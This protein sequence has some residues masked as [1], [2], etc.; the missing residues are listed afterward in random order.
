MKPPRHL[1]R[2]AFCSIALFLYAHALAQPRAENLIRDLACGACHEGLAA[3]DSIAFKA[4]SLSYAGIRYNPAYLFEY[5]GNPKRVR[6]HIGS[7]R[8]PD[9]FL[10]EKERIALTFFLAQQKQYDHPLPIFPGELLRAARKNSD[11]SG[12]KV[13]EELKCT[14]CH[15]L[16]NSGGD[17]AVEL[18]DAGAR[19]QPGWLIQYLALPQAYDLHSAMPAQLYARSAIG[20]KLEEMWPKAASKLRSVTDFLVEV[21]GAERKRLEMQFNQAR[22]RNR[23]ITPE[24]GR[25]IFTALNCAGCHKLGKMEGWFN[26]PNLSSE[27]ARVQSRWLAGYIAKPQPI[28]PFGYYPGTGGRMPDFRLTA[29]EARMVT[30]FFL[31]QNVKSDIHFPAIQLSRFSVQKA[32]KLMKENLPCLGCHLLEGEGGKIGPDLSKASG[33]LQPEYLAS[34]IR[35]PKHTNPAIIMPKA[36]MS[37]DISQLVV[38]Y[39][40]SLKTQPSPSSYLSL[41]E[42]QTFVKPDSSAAG[43]Y[44]QYCSPCHGVSG[45]GDGFNASYLPV[46]PASHLSKEMSLRSDHTIFDGISNGAGILNKSNRMP[47][48][49]FML[50]RTQIWSLVRHIRD[51]CKCKRPTWSNAHERD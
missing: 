39:I 27:G 15:Q 41:T 35:D 22:L 43:I 51:L 40:I 42:N 21:S 44:V 4:P 23:S 25:K 45:N 16:E 26:G 33:R 20:N 2:F 12:K 49:G 50:N 1:A 7:A 5:L 32:G 18:G 8:M 38:S 24:T 6:K 47:G 46:K 14:V 48:F 31:S 29:D 9:F 3:S 34:I 13:I 36:P 11:D 17:I 28:R 37:Q 10:D 30:N 19:L